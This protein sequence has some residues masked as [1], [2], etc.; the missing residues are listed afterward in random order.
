MICSSFYTQHFIY[1][2]HSILN[3]FIYDMLIILYSTFY[4]CSSF[5]TQHFIYDMLII[6]YS[7]FHFSSVSSEF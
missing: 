1:V 5:Y 2:H 4:I 3:I 7:T 6:L